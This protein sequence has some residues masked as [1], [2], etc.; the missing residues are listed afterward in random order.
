MDPRAPGGMI[1][2][3]IRLVAIN[4][5]LILFF[6]SAPLHLAFQFL[7]PCLKLSHFS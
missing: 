5:A 6:A 4:I 7:V 2:N 3:I 1:G